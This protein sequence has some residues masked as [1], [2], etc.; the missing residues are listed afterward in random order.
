[1]GAV[2]WN[3]ASTLRHVRPTR[4]TNNPTLAGITMTRIAKV[5]LHWLISAPAGVSPRG[6][7]FSTPARFEHQGEDWT[8]DAWS[9]VITIEG[10]ANAGDQQL[11]SAR[12]LMPNAPQDWL[13]V[14]KHFTLF[15]GRLPIAEGVVEEILSNERDG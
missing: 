6:A 11:A 4:A 10:F 9:L 14:G 1:M 7:R 3:W 2:G 13:S 5:L 15:E 8:H 12:F